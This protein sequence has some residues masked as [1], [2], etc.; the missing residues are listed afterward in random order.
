MT[1]WSVHKMDSNQATALAELQDRK[2]RAAGQTDLFSLQV[3]Y[4][5]LAEILEVYVNTV[6]IIA[7]HRDQ[8]MAD[9]TEA[10]QITIGIMTPRPN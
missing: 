4:L 10:Y 7:D 1:Y 5:E 9:L 3:E 6:Q 8:L 2:E